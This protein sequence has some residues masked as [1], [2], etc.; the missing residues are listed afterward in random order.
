MY[1]E[2]WKA[3]DDI[4]SLNAELAVKSSKIKQLEL[5]FRSKEREFDRV[6]DEKDAIRAA[7]GERAKAAEDVAVKLETELGQVGSMGCS[8]P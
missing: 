7:G 2:I 5:A 1:A 6:R 4:R 8:L 3:E